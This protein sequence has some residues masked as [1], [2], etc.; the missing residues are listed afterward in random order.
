MSDEGELLP[1]EHDAIV[2]LL[3]DIFEEPEDGEDDA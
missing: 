3:R 2:K 1:G